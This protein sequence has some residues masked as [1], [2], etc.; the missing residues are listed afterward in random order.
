MLT[1]DQTDLP[2]THTSIHKWNEPYLP[3]LP[4]RRVS[5]HFDRYFPSHWGQEDELAWVAWWNTEVTCPP[6]VTHLS[7]RQW[8]GI[9]LATILCNG[10]PP[11]WSAIHPVGYLSPMTL[12][13]PLVCTLCVQMKPF[14]TNNSAYFKQKLII[15]CFSLRRQFQSSV[16]KAT[17]FWFLVVNIWRVGKFMN[18]TIAM[19]RAGSLHKMR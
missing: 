11:L 16:A 15:L 18:V 14:Y 1:R 8:L 12:C 10:Y 19:L 3:L 9:E 6:K 13:R 17:V 2:A 4:S 7:T 5:L